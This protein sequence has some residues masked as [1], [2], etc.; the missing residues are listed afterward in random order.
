MRHDQLL[1]QILQLQCHVAIAQV[2]CAD[3]KEYAADWLKEAK[4]VTRDASGKFASKATRLGEAVVKTATTSAVITKDLIQDKGFRE[5]VGLTS[6][7]VGFEAIQKVAEAVK[8]DPS[9][10]KYFESLV[11]SIDKR[12]FE[13]YGQD[14]D[15]IHQ[16]VRKSK[17]PISSDFASKMEFYV[18]AYENLEKSLKNPEEVALPQPEIRQRIIKSLTPIAV[19]MALAVGPEVLV[20]LALE[21]SLVSIMTHAAASQTAAWAGKKIAKANDI[22]NPWANLAIDLAVGIFTSKV[23]QINPTDISKVAKNASKEFETV[24]KDFIDTGF[25]FPSNR[26]FAF[27]PLKSVEGVAQGTSEFFTTKIGKHTYFAKILPYGRGVGASCQD[28]TYKIAKI[29]G[30]KD[31]LVPSKKVRSFGREFVVSPFLPKDEIKK[32]TNEPVQNLSKKILFEF[33]AQ[34]DDQNSGNFIRFNG[35]SR[36]VDYE[37]SLGHWQFDS[38]KDQIERHGFVPLMSDLRYDA[39]KAG[40]VFKEQEIKDVLGKRS[41]IEKVIKESIKNSKTRDTALQLVDVQMSKLAKMLAEKKLSAKE[42]LFIRQ[43]D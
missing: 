25:V 5:R 40:T 35:A 9:I 27:K 15:A 20:G 37:F 1:V 30:A 41:E 23:M 22:D 19:T 11:D 8:A 18:A 2:Q 33:L 29:L 28:A 12:L 13:Y 34:I 3:L 10:E 43:Y 6:K 14:K 26:E 7:K 16:A 42:L 31:H 4:T 36:I 39:I 38:V 21:E 32:R 17:P 24:S